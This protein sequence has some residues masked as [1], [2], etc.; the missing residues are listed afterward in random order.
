MIQKIV[1]SVI[2]LFLTTSL[3]AQDIAIGEW[4]A[5]LP[6]R[7]GI[8]VTQSE[9]KVYLAYEAQIA[10]VDKE[11]LSIE[12]LHKVNGLSDVNIRTIRYNRKNLTLLVAYENGNIDLI[13]DG[14]INNIVHIKETLT[15]T[16]KAINHI[17]FD[18]DYA[19]LACNFG[20]VQ[21][22]VVRNEIKGTFPFSNPERVNATA[23]FEGKIYAFTN[24]GVFEGDTTLNLLDF[25]KWKKQDETNNIWT[26]TKSLS[27][28]LFQDK[29]YADID[30]TLKVFENNRWENFTVYEW[31]AGAFD[32]LSQ[33]YNASYEIKYI[34]PNYTNTGMV[35]TWNGKISPAR[36][37][38]LSS[39]GTYFIGYN[40]QFFANLSQ[41]IADEKGRRWYVDELRGGFYQAGGTNSAIS[42]NA[43]FNEGVQGLAVG[44]N[45][46][47]WVASGTIE[48]WTGT[49]D[50]S[51]TYL[52]NEGFWK[53]YSDNS[54]VE[55]EGVP[56]HIRV[57]NHP[58]ND[59]TYLGTF[60]NGIVEVDGEN[61]T[62]YKEGT[63]LQPD[64]LD[65]SKYKISGLTFD[66]DG[67]LWVSNYGADRPI[68]VFKTDGTWESFNA[69]SA[70][71]RITDVI[72]D[73]N[74]YKW[75]ATKS[76]GSGSGILVF[77]EGDLNV[78]GDERYA[79]LT[80]DNTE[81]PNNDVISLA[82]DLDGEVWVGTS[83]GT[84]LFECTFDVFE[85]TCPGRRV[86]TSA[87]DFGDYLLK[88]Q[89]INTVLVD[90][91]N[92]K[93]FGTT[94]GIFVQSDDGEEE[95]L[96]FNVDN[97]PLYSNNIT[98]LA[99]DDETGE[100][101]IGTDRGL[102]SYKSDATKGTETHDETAIIAYPN[103][104]RPDYEGPIAIRG[105]V[106]EANV[107][108]T[109]INGVL[110]YET[111]SNGGQA[112][113]DGKDYNGRKA[114]SGVYLVFSSRKDG[115]DAMVT[116]ILFIN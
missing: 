109:D 70:F 78:V 112:I 81:L 2:V 104:V 47:V 60:G 23:V 3:I 69:P 73:Y 89:T 45:S 8:S 7:K 12:R 84:M 41:V 33:F 99:M 36:M 39:D 28:T 87:N 4:N 22:N 64:V 110:I 26:D 58:T 42:P 1:S 32:T 31:S 67:N 108:I 35:I 83:Q 11:E 29:M 92:R 98:T 9:D 103:P 97:S 25:S 93:W 51:G 106:E 49:G 107:K 53:R 62:V 38:T 14:Q 48:N 91:A 5:H 86:V 72:V 19:Y 85:G 61:I 44:E 43:P 115:L 79:V 21:I 15:Y 71:K 66:E 113:W 77:D 27:A 111:R 68:S 74:G 75:F 16:D 105:L 94:A 52:L 88:S 6:F 101:Y 80:S 96:R 50:N 17:S 102:I 24:E 18:G 90:G 30:D 46:Q 37:T 95:V 57:V 116:K 82:V 59:K 10:I 63:S 54:Y 100:V 20:V 13:K 76:S 40:P 56:D 65:Q 55:L 114:A 34:E